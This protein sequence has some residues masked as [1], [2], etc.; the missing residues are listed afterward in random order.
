ADGRDRVPSQHHLP[1]SHLFRGIRDTS[2]GALSPPVSLAYRNRYLLFDLDLDRFGLGE[3]LT[4]FARA[5]QGGPEAFPRF[6]VGASGTTGEENLAA[7]GAGAE[8]PRPEGRPLHDKIADP[9]RK[10]SDQ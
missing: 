1:H 9:G 5:H 2:R 4:A 6:D 8:L 10:S 3:L 7:G